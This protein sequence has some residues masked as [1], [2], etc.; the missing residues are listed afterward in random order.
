MYDEDVNRVSP[1]GENRQPQEVSEP[2]EGSVVAPRAPFG[3]HQ[4]RRIVGEGDGGHTLPVLRD[5]SLWCLALRIDLMRALQQNATSRSR[6]SLGLFDNNKAERTLKDWGAVGRSVMKRYIKEHWST[7]RLG[8]AYTIEDSKE[9]CA[10]YRRWKLAHDL[11][12][13]VSLKKKLD[14]FV[15]YQKMYGVYMSRVLGYSLGIHVDRD[16]TGPVRGS[17]SGRDSKDRVSKNM[18]Q[19]LWKMCFVELQHGYVTRDVYFRTTDGSVAPKQLHRVQW[20][21]G[22]PL[23]GNSNV[24]VGTYPVVEGVDAKTPERAAWAL[25]PFVK[26]QNRERCFPV[27]IS[28][29]G[30]IEEDM[31]PLEKGESKSGSLEDLLYGK[32][33]HDKWLTKI[34]EVAVSVCNGVGGVIGTLSGGVN[35]YFSNMKLLASLMGKDQS[36]RE[37]GDEKKGMGENVGTEDPSYEVDHFWR[38]IDPS[39]EGGIF[40]HIYVI[41]P[42][43]RRDVIDG[44]EERGI[45]M[46]V[47]FQMCL[48]R[49]VVMNKPVNI[50]QAKTALFQTWS[51]S[52][53]A[54]KDDYFDTAGAMK[55]SVEKSEEDSFTA[56]L[57]G[58]MKRQLDGRMSYIQ[59]SCP[60]PEVYDRKAYAELSNADDMVTGRLAISLLD[61]YDKWKSHKDALP[62]HLFLRMIAIEPVGVYDNILE[63]I[64]DLHEELTPGMHQKLDPEPPHPPPSRIP[65]IAPSPA[66][67]ADDDNCLAPDGYTRIPKSPS[68]SR[69]PDG[70]VNGANQKVGLGT[71]CKH[72]CYRQDVQE[73]PPAPYRRSAR[74]AAQ[75]KEGYGYSVRRALMP[76]RSFLL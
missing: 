76:P 62:L 31:P 19:A 6:S 14:N 4:I 23:W 7:S 66:R 25:H 12:R 20:G 2:K 70:S 17:P 1:G 37:G 72:Y 50:D 21:R 33:L 5:L 40:D 38:A 28:A 34:A 29:S 10:V 64:K 22:T 42:Y 68:D 15:V 71:A 54:L 3:I 61:N 55:Q 44:E 57:T 45:T 27:T 65:Q 51:E 56:L 49:A 8:P 30:T 59:W 26:I 16:V 18:L 60:V 63:H 53:T 46:A 58:E 67:Q 69:C 35:D 13:A 41:N 36:I 9:A 47:R 52:F 24:L 73:A 75:K 32:V 39:E 43:S 11:V 74:L 48:R